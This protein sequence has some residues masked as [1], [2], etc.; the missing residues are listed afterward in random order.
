MYHADYTTKHLFSTLLSPVSL[1]IL[2]LR[3]QTSAD[4]K[5]LRAGVSEISIV[6]NLYFIGSHV[7][8]VSLHVCFKIFQKNQPL[9]YKSYEQKQNRIFTV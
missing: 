1:Q 8:Y 5:A 7:L 4:K 2:F 3:F 9:F 6:M